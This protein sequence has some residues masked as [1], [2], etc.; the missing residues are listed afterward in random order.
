MSDRIRDI[1]NKLNFSDIS[2]DHA[3]LLIDGIIQQVRADAM[4]ER[5]ARA[6]E[7][8]V[9]VERL[10]EA[11]QGSGMAELSV[12]RGDILRMIEELDQA[13]G[14][15]DVDRLTMLVSGH[16]RMLV[17]SVAEPIVLGATLVREIKEGRI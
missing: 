5:T 3:E 4:S 2:T 9:A 10:R 16:M 1:L 17:D 8:S 7:L 11:A 12:R 15:L 14:R 6:T 13:E